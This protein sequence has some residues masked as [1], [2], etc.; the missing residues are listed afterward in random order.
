[1]KGGFLCAGLTA[2]S[3]Y[4]LQVAYEKIMLAEATEAGRQQR[5]QGGYSS[6]LKADVLYSRAQKK[7]GQ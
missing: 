3:D 1:M 2:V 4:P 7:G 5:K 6:D